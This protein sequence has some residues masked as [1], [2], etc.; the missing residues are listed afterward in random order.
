M[1]EGEMAA[2]SPNNTVMADAA[3][4]RGAIVTSYA[5]VEHLLADIVLRCQPMAE[6]S[7]LPQTF[8]YKTGNP[9]RAGARHC[10]YGWPV[11]KIQICI[12][13]CNN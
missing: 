3:M 9:H 12:R 5:Q 4:L 8:P 10:W 1:E 6:Y 2:T 11:T 13:K 7:N